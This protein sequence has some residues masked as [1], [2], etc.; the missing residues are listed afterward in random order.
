MVL[1]PQFSDFW[2][3]GVIL[4]RTPG[5]LQY[6]YYYYVVFVLHVVY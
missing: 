6:L 2:V 5:I 3:M 4:L 1:S